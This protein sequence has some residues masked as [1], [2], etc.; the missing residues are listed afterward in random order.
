MR[1]HFLQIGLI[2]AA[3]AC[4]L[5]LLAKPAKQGIL[6][7]E[8]A[9]GT[10][11]RV[12]LAGDESF[13]QY[14]TEDG[15]P[16]LERG[17]NFYYCDIAANG[18]VVDSGIKAGQADARGAAARTFLAKVDKST[19]E[20]RVSARA[21][22]AVKRTSGAVA[23]G[24]MKSPAQAADGNDG[25]PYEKGYGL[26]PS[27]R[28]SQFPAYGDQRA[29]V[30]L[31]EYTDVKF[32][33]AADGYAVDAK[34]YFTRMLNE[35][36]FSDLGATGSAAEFYRFNSQ[37]AFRPVFDVYGPVQLAH[38]MAY[39]GGNTGWGGDDQR[40]EQMVVE[41]CDILDDE[42][43][44][45]Q[46]D[47]DGDG[48]VDNIFV[49]YA[50]RGEASGGP[51]NS[52][53]PH[54]WDLSAAGYGNE[55][56]DGVIVDRYGCSNEWESGRPDGV[57]TFV[58]EFSHVMGLPDLYA[59]SYTGAFTPGAWSCMDYG[60][61]N[62]DGMTPPNYGAFERYALGW[63]KPREVT[64]A[65]SATLQ[66]VSE[67]VCGVIRTPKDTEFFLLE[68][69]QQ[70]GWD[71]FIPGHGMLIWHIDYDASVWNRNVVN[72]TPSHQYV[73]IEEADG[74][75]E[76]YSMAGDSFPGT[77]HKTSFTSSTKPAMK[78]WGGVAINYPITNIA[79]NGGLIT[80]DVLGGAEAPAIP[81]AAAAPA[82]DVTTESFTARWEKASG[83][84][85][86]LSVYYYED[87]QS[88]AR[89]AA[90]EQTKVYLQGFKSRN[91]GDTDSYPVTGLEP[92]RVYFYTVT[93]STGWYNGAESD[94]VPVTTGRLTLDYYA[95]KAMEASGI[96]DN[97][98]TANWEALEG[99]DDYI[100]NVYTKVPG[101]PY[102]DVNGFDNG[103]TAMGEWS[104]NSA[105]SYGNESYSGQ[106]VPS[107][108]LA[109]AQYLE[110]P[111]YADKISGI[112]FWHRGN[113]TSTGDQVHVFAYN[114]D[115][116]ETLV[117]KVDIDKQVGGVV[118]DVDGFPADA[119]KARLVF[120]RAGDKGSLA[121]DD[122]KV[123]HG[124]RMTPAPVEG[125]TGL[126]VGDVC[127]EA[128]SGLNPATC[129]FYTVQATD[130]TYMS[131]VSREIEVNTGNTGVDSA[132]ADGFAVSVSGLAVTCTGDETIIVSDYTG[133][134]VARGAHKVTLPRAGLYVVTVPAR[135]YAAKIIV[136]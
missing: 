44:F 129:Y 78:T 60:P 128:V 40:P 72:N 133:A 23:P 119:V 89:R 84:D 18:D 57:G 50:G 82:E 4:G 81:A 2:T 99:A 94:E 88:A 124:R 53:W 117:S 55:V 74:T 9:D 69:R 75:Q 47:R 98:F 35:D 6:T 31:V 79:E 95:V 102:A 121:L 61:Y 107:L 39:Y 106:A 68:N 28:G 105:S 8:T 77:A 126:H 108:R 135:D 83:Y 5:Q 130:G 120:V 3:A 7:V 13:H 38:N 134:L 92:D 15:Y 54:A 45:S 22:R 12:R 21:A 33:T 111:V 59:T 71:E 104:S 26:F 41:A 110:T 11:L 90:G 10:E 76:E 64:E 123:L 113:N 101:E 52:V 24:L 32:H 20:T 29:I 16:L 36:G 93:T 114:A 48:Y 51:A 86:L 118:T 37:D 34:D 62:N 97:G 17:G 49:F 112:S 46:Y 87:S 116:S 136:K 103:V 122:V 58:H 131:K 115:G 73:D 25:P 65:L 1:K 67:N 100:L 125:Y 80:F 30:I 91:V 70:E 109:S 132:T 63:V 27:S 14:F 96:S 42:V 85:H 56:H 19:L 127:S 66:P 43:D